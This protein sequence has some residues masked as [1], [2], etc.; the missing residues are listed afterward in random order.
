MRTMT[1]LSE[2]MTTTTRKLAVIFFLLANS[3]LNSNS[4]V[5]V[6]PAVP[7]RLPL[8]SPLLPVEVCNSSSVEVLESS[9]NQLIRTAAR[10]LLP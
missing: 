2:Q 7:S 6:F 4:D 8:K 3:K 9:L 10:P 1:S 5:A